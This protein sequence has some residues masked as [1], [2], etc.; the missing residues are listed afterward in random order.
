MSGGPKGQSPGTESQVASAESSKDE[1]K[2][3]AQV[4]QGRCKGGRPTP[5]HILVHNSNSDAVVC[6]RVCVC[7]CKCIICWLCATPPNTP[8]RHHPGSTPLKYPTPLPH[9]RQTKPCRLK[10][11]QKSFGRP[12]DGASSWEPKF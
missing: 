6:P 1:K 5:L 12:G 9:E 3:T 8:F 4:V 2:S 7:V 10:T 11:G